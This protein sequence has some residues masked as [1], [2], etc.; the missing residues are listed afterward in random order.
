MRSGSGTVCQST[1][2]DQI[3]VP[4]FAPRPMIFYRPGS[5]PGAMQ[6]IPQVQ[7]NAGDHLFHE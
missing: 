3:D 2:L 5:I 4:V 6:S 1:L 7:W